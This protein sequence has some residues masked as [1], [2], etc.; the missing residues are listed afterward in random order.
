[1]KQISGSLKVGGYAHVL[2]ASRKPGEHAR[3]GVGELIHVNATQQLPAVGG[4]FHWAIKSGGGQIVNKVNGSA[5]Y[6]A[7]DFTALQMQNALTEVDVL[8]C[9]KNGVNQEVAVLKLTIVRP[10]MCGLMKV[11]DRH[12][13]GSANAGFWGQPVMTP[14][15]VSFVNCSWRENKGV[16]NVT[17]MGFN[18]HVGAIHPIGG[19]MLGDK[20]IPQGTLM[21]SVDNVFTPAQT[22]PGGWKAGNSIT[23]GTM[24]WDVAWEYK[25]TS[26]ASPSGL[27]FCKGFHQSTLTAEGKVKTEKGG[28]SHTASVADPT[29]G[30]P[31]PP[32]N[33]CPYPTL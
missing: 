32:G 9:F 11:G 18:Q 31:M 20:V 6:T 28:G 22:P 27:Q 12:V 16:V 1:M 33:S 21:A 5:D 2:V 24:V 23:I 13:T 19:W 14:N 25:L 30:D 3:Y 7:P 10:T 29:V 4:P 8:L 17:G 15:D 26:D